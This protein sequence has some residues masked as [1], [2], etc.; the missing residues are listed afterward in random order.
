[1]RRCLGIET[2]LSDTTA[3]QSTLP[4]IAGKTSNIL[5]IKDLRRIS[6]IFKMVRHMR[7]GSYGIGIRHRS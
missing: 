7:G 1:M 2:A 5:W 6:Q 3:A 4:L